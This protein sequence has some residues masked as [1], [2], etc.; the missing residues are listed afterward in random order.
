MATKEVWEGECRGGPMDGQSGESRYP[1]GFLL[2]DKGSARAWIY[3]WDSSTRQFL[4]R[5]PMGDPLDEEG[6]R[7]A[8]NA[9]TYDVR[10]L[11]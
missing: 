4:V 7:K 6:R 2:V 1:K 9:H 8:A 3:D 11:P 10:V 5:D